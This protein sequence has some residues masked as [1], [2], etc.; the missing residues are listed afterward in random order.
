MD[1]KK[2][3]QVGKMCD[4]E[5]V[6]HLFVCIETLLPLYTTGKNINDRY[7]C[8]RLQSHEGISILRDVEITEKM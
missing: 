6:T 2:N 8:F 4:Y 5:R 1:R 3:I 7:N